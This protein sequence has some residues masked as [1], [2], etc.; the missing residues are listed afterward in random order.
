M[1]QFYANLQTGIDSYLLAKKAV[2]QLSQSKAI[3]FAIL[4][5]V[6]G[7]MRMGLAQK[8]YL[9]AEKC[10]TFIKI[11]K[12]AYTFNLERKTYR[13]KGFYLLFKLAGRGD[14]YFKKML[15]L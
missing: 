12:L 6:L 8:N 5:M 4:K 13:I 7:V 1:N 10:F 9:D 11:E 3:K 2:L 14:T 15:K